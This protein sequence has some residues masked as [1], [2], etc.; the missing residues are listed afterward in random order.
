MTEPSTNL[1]LTFVNDFLSTTTFA[2][3]I[4][5]SEGVASSIIARSK[6][7]YY[8]ESSDHRTH[9]TLNCV[10]LHKHY[11]EVR[12][13]NYFAKRHEARLLDEYSA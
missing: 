7:M 1:Y 4:G 13:S 6:I 12:N 5:V 3:W 11:K 2:D 9:F 8:S 10:K